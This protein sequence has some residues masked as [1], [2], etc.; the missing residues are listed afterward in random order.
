MTDRIYTKPL[1][2][3]GDADPLVVEKW[4][5]DTGNGRKY[6]CPI[7]D[8]M[9]TKNDFI[10]WGPYGREIIPGYHIFYCDTNI[11]WR[12]GP[13]QV[14]NVKENEVAKIAFQDVQKFRSIPSLAL[15]A[16]CFLDEYLTKDMKVFEWGSGASTLFFAMRNVNCITVEHSKEWY[17]VLIAAMFYRD[18]SQKSIYLIE[19][20]NGFDS[21]YA[22]VLPEYESVNFRRYVDSISECD[23]GVFDLVLV[24]GRSRRAC[25]EVAQSKVKPGGVLMLD[26]AHRVLYQYAMSKIDWPILDCYGSIP[27][28]PY[29]QIVKTT[30]WV[31]GL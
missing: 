23:D 31:K 21:D 3:L 17:E 30:A 22:S 15:S 29:N 24:D 5:T 10:G 9:G 27:Y 16:V 4:Q 26:D 12:C 25:L 11:H 18:L 1:T 28:R 6:Y 13:L 2:E 7:C 8:C 19:P 14:V 20:E